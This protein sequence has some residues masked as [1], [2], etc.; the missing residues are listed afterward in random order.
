MEEADIER[1]SMI[2]K[3]AD[4]LQ[5]VQPNSNTYAGQAA[6]K[7]RNVTAGP[8]SEAPEIPCLPIKRETPS[9]SLPF[10]SRVN[11]SVY[12]APIKRTLSRDS[13]EKEEEASASYIPGE[14]AIKEYSV[15]QFGAVASPYISAYAYRRGNLD[16]EF[17]MRRDVDG[18]FRIGN[19]GIE[20]DQDSNVYVMGKSHTGTRGL[21]VLL[22]RK[23]V[24]QSFITDRDLKSYREI[25][26]ATHGHFENNDPSG[27]IKTTR[28]AKFK[29][30]ISKLFP[31]GGVTRR[32]TQSTSRQKW[33]Y[34]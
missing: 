21:F 19:A 18:Q 26:R 7:T 29:D 31:T 20:I 3:I 15:K 33:D 2:Q 34:Y 6:P 14:T 28:G 8:I 12:A 10:M 9:H 16:R 5:K 24:D 22:T 1:K 4:F 17:G 25:L 32:S 27:V 11:E 13:D 23:K 30:V